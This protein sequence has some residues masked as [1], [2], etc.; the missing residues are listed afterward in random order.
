VS[1][2]SAIRS[3][4]IFIAEKRFVMLLEPKSGSQKL[5]IVP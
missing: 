2:R 3:T 5:K 4:P 1:G